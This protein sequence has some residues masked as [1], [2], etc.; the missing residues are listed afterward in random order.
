MLKDHS[1]DNL[2]ARDTINANVQLISKYTVD[3]QRDISDLQEMLSVIMVYL[4]NEQKNIDI[5]YNDMPIAHL[6][7]V[8]TLVCDYCDKI[9]RM[10]TMIR[11]ML[12]EIDKSFNVEDPDIVEQRKRLQKDI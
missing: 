9:V 4:N 11:Q 1:R 3:L 8:N 12:Y 6:H 2:I 10:D 7:N 5:H